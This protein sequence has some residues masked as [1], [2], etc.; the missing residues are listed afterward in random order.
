MTENTKRKAPRHLYDTG[1][2][3]TLPP[4]RQIRPHMFVNGERNAGPHLKADAS[5]P[6]VWPLAGPSTDADPT[7]QVKALPP[8][9]PL[10]KPNVVIGPP[11]RAK[12][13]RRLEKWCL[14]GAL[15][16]AAAAAVAFVVVNVAAVS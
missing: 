13:A 1:T 3:K 4:E 8:F 9:P 2:F 10:P 5:K 6:V 11:M 12:D 7:R 16:V 15:V 14:I